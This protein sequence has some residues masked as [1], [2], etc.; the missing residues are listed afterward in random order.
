MVKKRAKGGDADGGFHDV[1][2]FRDEMGA[3]VA[4]MS[5]AEIRGIVGEN[6]AE[7]NKLAAPAR[8]AFDAVPMAREQYDHMAN[9]LRARAE[10]EERERRRVE[11]ELANE[12]S[13]RQRAES[14]QYDLS[15][16]QRRLRNELE[17]ERIRRLDNSWRSSSLDDYLTKE[18]IKRDVKEELLEEKKR[19][20]RQKELDKLWNFDTPKKRSPSK[21]RSK[22]RKKAK[23]KKRGKSRKK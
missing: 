4:H 9:N 22:S 8:A 13:R 15:S 1:Q 14:S 18:K 19:A 10:K 12:R 2:S 16:S 23:S 6:M 17:L 11:N 5:D 21:K 7:R 20:K 3:D